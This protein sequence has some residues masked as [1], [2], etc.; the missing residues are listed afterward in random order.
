MTQNLQSCDP[1]ALD[2]RSLG[3]GLALGIGGIMLLAAGMGV[4]KTLSAGEPIV[5]SGGDGRHAFLW[6]VSGDQIIFVSSARADGGKDEDHGKPEDPKD[7]GK[8]ADKE[9]GKD[10]DKDKGKGKGKNPGGG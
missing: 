4:G 6:R 2:R 9:K 10:G 3:L 1:R 8:D 5:T 7:K